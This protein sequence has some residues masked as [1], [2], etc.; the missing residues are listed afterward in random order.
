MVRIFI[1]I[2][3]AFVL[4]LV[5]GRIFIPMLRALKAGQSIRE[6]GPSWHN[7]KSG[8]PTIGGIIFIAAMVVSI[9]AGIGNPEGDFTHLFVLAFALVFWAATNISSVLGTLGITF[10]KVQ[11]AP[12]PAEITAV[13]HISES[14]ELATEEA[15]LVYPYELTLVPA[16]Q[17]E[18][19]QQLR[20]RCV[21]SLC[22]ELQ[23]GSWS[24]CR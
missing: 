17:P 15:E 2:V 12:A 19:V 21:R 11:P 23:T 16:V 13:D 10:E 22:R 7:V 9:F 6:I 20:R 3:C 14:E 18:P 1:A 8:T 5:L 4:G 24:C